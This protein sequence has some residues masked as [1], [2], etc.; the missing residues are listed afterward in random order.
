MPLTDRDRIWHAGLLLVALLVVTVSVP[1]TEVQA[2]EGTGAD[3]KQSADDADSKAG[4]DAAG[5]AG[6]A[7]VVSKRL[8]GSAPEVAPQTKKEYQ[9]DQRR[10]VQELRRMQMTMTPQIIASYKEN[11]RDFRKLLFQGI[12]R[13][14][15]EQLDILKSGLKYEVL[16]L[17]DQDIQANPL[18]LENAVKK[19]R[20]DLGRAGSGIINKAAKAKYREMICAEV[21]T[22]LQGLMK[23]NLIARS[24]AIDMLQDLEVESATGGGRLTMYEK[25][26]GELVRVMM[27]NDQPDAVKLRVA[28]TMTNYLQAI[29][30]LVA[31]FGNR[32]TFF[33]GHS[34]GSTMAT[35]AGATNLH[36]IGFASIMCSA[37]PGS[38]LSSL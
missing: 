17:S 18:L 33:M 19:L 38:F 10:R 37:V 4:A 21:F 23:H 12:Q 22:L 13:G 25:V 14:N 31:Y 2:Q 34:R 28:N 36:S 16:S 6:E 3:S 1:Q 30:E 20:G 7:A 24:T 11:A 26:D 5:K 35:L 15:Q 29:N 8:P 27:D 9:L 32:P